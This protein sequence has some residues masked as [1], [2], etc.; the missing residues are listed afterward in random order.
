MLRHVV[1]FDL[2][3]DT[4]DAAIDAAVAGLLALRDTVPS[5]RA[6][7]C[8]RD[9]GLAEGNAGLALVVDTDDEAGW[10]A[11]QDHPEHVRVATT[12]VRP[13]MCGRTAAQHTL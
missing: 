9:A 7:S 11:Y 2:A 13:I 10:R 3:E 1:L 12:L 5:V 6:L 8:G 4:S